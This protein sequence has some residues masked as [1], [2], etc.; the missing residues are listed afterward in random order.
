MK[1][2]HVQNWI[3]VLV[4]GYTLLTMGEALINLCAFLIFSVGLALALVGLAQVLPWKK[5]VKKP[6]N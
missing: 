2:E 1:K 5:P 6:S 4:I 3:V